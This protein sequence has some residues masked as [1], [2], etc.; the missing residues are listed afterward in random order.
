[1]KRA[2]DTNR[3]LRGMALNARKNR[4]PT[5]LFFVFLALALY[6]FFV[7]TLNV[8]LCVEQPPVVE[9]AHNAGLFFAV[10]AALSA[11]L[12]FVNKS[13]HKQK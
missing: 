1:M 2:A 6:S 11:V 13:K 9:R 12:F 5:A 3:N 10:M 7:K 4:L 8:C